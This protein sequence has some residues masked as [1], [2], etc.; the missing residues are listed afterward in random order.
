MLAHQA[1]QDPQIRRWPVPQRYCWFLGVLPIAGMSPV[2]GCLLVGDEPATPDDYKDQA[3]VPLS[4]AVATIDAARTAGMVIAD[5]E[6]GCERV[7]NWKKHNPSPK[8]DNTAAE[9]QRRRR[10]KVAR[11]SNVTPLSRG[12]T[13]RDNTVTSRSVT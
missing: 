3:L 8:T 7:T 9:R 10:E 5:E 6:Y 13:D 11:E 12:V 1:A 2:R 4:V